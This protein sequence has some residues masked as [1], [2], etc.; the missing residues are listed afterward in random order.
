MREKIFQSVVV[1]AI[2]TFTIAAVAQ[3]A[4]FNVSTPAEFQ[5][6]LTTA[7]SNGEDDTVNVASGTYNLTAVLNYTVANGDGTLT[8]QAADSNSPPVLDGGDT[9][10]IID[11]NNDFDFSGNGD[12]GDDIV[13]VGLIFQAGNSMALNGGLSVTTGEANIELVNCIFRQNQG[14]VGG[15]AY[16]TSTSG[17]VTATGNSFEQNRASNYGGGLVA[18]TISGNMI[19]SNNTFTQNVA[20]VHAGGFNIQSDT[21]TVTVSENIFYQNSATNNGGG[22]V[23]WTNQGSVTFTNN[24]FN[25]NS[26]GANGG[27]VATGVLRTAVTL[28][29]NTFWGNT[30]RNGGGIYEYAS[31]DS[32]IMNIYNNIIYNNT[33]T[34][35]GNDGDDVYLYSDGDNNGVNVNLYNNDMGPDSDFT[36]AQSEDLYITNINN[37]SH[38]GN[39]MADPLLTDPA[40]GDFHLTATSPAINKG[41]NSAFSIPTTDFEGDQR[42]INGTVDIGADEY[43]AGPTTNVSVPTMTQWGMIIFMVLAGL[44]SAYCMKRMGRV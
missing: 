16:L 2:L 44:A 14:R 30:A 10:Q 27:G 7:S 15:G 8:I 5:S 33:A 32:A 38:A 20:S 42:I 39:I 34:Q 3:G 36:I 26:A 9:R 24:I 13:I 22:T 12:A 17:T 4:V 43:E 25:Q 23:V 35:G 37:Y 1:L 21:G 41:N 11:I 31:Q 29:N 40:N 19:V 6:A 18:I 28:T